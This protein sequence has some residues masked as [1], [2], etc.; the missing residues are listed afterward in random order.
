MIEYREISHTLYEGKVLGS[1]DTIYDVKIDTAHPKKSKCTCPFADG[2]LVVCKHMIALY[3]TVNPEAAKEIVSRDE[4]HQSEYE[5]FTEDSYRKKK[6][7]DIVDYVY[8]LNEAELRRELIQT[9]L[10]LEGIDQYF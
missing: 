2:R 6:Y 1:G 8:S 5:G 7:N 9:L 10:I 3:L 4:L